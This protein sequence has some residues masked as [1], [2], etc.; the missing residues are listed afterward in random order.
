[1]IIGY[2]LEIR[3][4]VGYKFLEGAIF[5]AQ[6]LAAELCYDSAT[7]STISISALR[8]PFSSVA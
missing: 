4:A 3:T 1:M 7:T 5:S 8:K 2:E 6:I